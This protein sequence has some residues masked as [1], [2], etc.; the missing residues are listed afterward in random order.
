[1]MKDNNLVRHLDA[2]ETMG[3]ATA[4]CSDKT[5]TLTTNRW[6]CLQFLPEDR[7]SP[8]CF[9]FAEWQ[10]S[11]RLFAT[12]W[13]RRVQ[14]F[15][16]YQL[17]SKKCSSSR[18]PSTRRTLRESWSVRRLSDL[19][20]LL[21][22]WSLCLSAGRTWWSSKANWQQNWVCP[23]WLRNQ[24]EQKLREG[25]I[26]NARGDVHSR[27]H[28][29]LGPQVDGHCDQ[30]NQ[31]RI[32]PVRQGCFWN[33]AEKVS[34]TAK[35]SAAP[36]AVAWKKRESR[37]ITYDQGSMTMAGQ[38]NAHWVLW[39]LFNTIIPTWALKIKSWIWISSCSHGW[40]T[41]W[42]VRALT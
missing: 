38:L 12:N 40:L 30:A 41:S 16:E 8:E 20:H 14:I 13:Q 21:Y 18:S 36:L 39:A 19:R 28:L 10:S 23:A 35:N 22:I 15:A 4:I 33:H 26:G 31:R 24:H 7:F 2:C 17:P 5:G 1:M 42:C 34:R 32:P 6:V 11:R 29:Q 9:L 27:L 25:A 3:N 37:T